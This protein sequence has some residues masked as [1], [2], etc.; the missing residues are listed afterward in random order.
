MSFIELYSTKQRI[1]SLPAEVCVYDMLK[2]VTDLRRL[3]IYAKGSVRQV[4]LRLKVPMWKGK[5]L[6]AAKS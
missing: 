3:K 1:A 6:N 2:T 4:A 5:G